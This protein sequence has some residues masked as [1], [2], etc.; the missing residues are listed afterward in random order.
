MKLL[1]MILSVLSV[2]CGSQTH[3]SNV[4]REVVQGVRETC[5]FKKSE[6]QYLFYSF[7]RGDTSKKECGVMT[8]DHVKT[9]TVSDDS[10]GDSCKFAVGN[11]YYIAV[12]DPIKGADFYDNNANRFSLGGGYFIDRLPYFILLVECKQNGKN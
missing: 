1:V 6:T 4:Q 12:P 10:D 9:T 8:K 2:A 5:Y 7:T 3:T 11:R